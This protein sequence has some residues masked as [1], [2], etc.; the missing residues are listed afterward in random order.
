MRLPTLCLL[1]TLFVLAVLGLGVSGCG[2]ADPPD[3]LAGTS[4]QLVRIESM[5]PD[6]QPDT[7]IDDPAKYT[8]SFDADGSGRDAFQVDCNRGS[9]TWQG[10]TSGPDS[11]SLTFGP[12][13]LT[14]MACPTPSSDA[15]VAA[16][17][18][19]VRSYLLSDGKLHLSLEADSGIMHFTPMT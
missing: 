17:L 5:A 11:G 16:A 4:W 12:I 18:S 3:P 2:S 13:A 14:K 7:T 19:R 1:P 15:V 9:A 10:A 8:V 6:E